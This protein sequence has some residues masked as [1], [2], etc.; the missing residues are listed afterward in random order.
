MALQF[1]I[2]GAGS[3][4][5]CT[6]FRRIIE[7]S[8]RERRQRFL[9]LVPEQS[10]METQRQIVGLHDRGGI[11]NIEVLSMTRLA[12]RVFS[13]LGDRKEELLEEIGKTFL[14]KKIAMDEKKNLRFFGDLLLKPE[15]LAQ[16]KA[17]ISEFLLYGVTPEML[18]GIAGEG[19]E[20][21]GGSALALKLADLSLLY[22]EFRR[23]L[24]GSYMTA[25]EIPER[26]SRLVLRSAYLRDSVIALDG[27]TGFTPL[28]LVLIEKLMTVSR[29]F[30][31]TVTMDAEESPFRPFRTNELFCLSGEMVQSL[32]EIARRT[33]TPIAAPYRVQG[34]GRHAGAPGLMALERS[35][36]RR[37]PAGMDGG[38]VRERSGKQEIRLLYL[39]SPREEIRRT[40][41]EI[42][43]LVRKEGMRYRDFA[44]VTADLHTYGRYV[45]ELFPE[46]EI[47]FFIDE[48]RALKL[49]PFMEY[50]RAAL[51]AVTEQY[52]I[53]GMLRMLKSGMTDFRKEE[54]DCLENYV[55]ALGIK[56]KER[57]HKPFV[58]HYR[59]EDPGEVPLL[60]GL[61][62]RILALLDPFAEG[63]A[64]RAGTVREK[65]AAL[66]EFCLRSRAEERLRERGEMYREQGRPDLARE[67]AQI[68]PYIVSFLDKLV[69]VLGDEAI[70]MK[71]YRELVEAGFAEGRLAIIPPGNDQVLVGD[72]ERSRLSGVRV[73]FFVGVNEGLVPK[74][75]VSTSILTQADRDVL[76]ER[77]ISLKPSS[78]TQIYIDR[79]YLYLTLT[80]PSR[81]LV[82][83]CCA[84]TPSGE[85]ARPS[86]LIDTVRT[87]FP[88][89][90][91]EEET[92]SLAAAVERESTGISLL[93]RG[94]SRLNEE[95]PGSDFKELFSYYRHHP[96]YGKR[97]CLLLDAA[98]T[99]KDGDRI[100]RAAARALYGDVL[101]NSAS[102]LEL[103][104]S[105]RYAH[106]LAYGLKLRPRQ[107]CEFTGLDM[108]S[109]L[110]R[111]F[112]LFQKRLQE[113]NRS[114]SSF[115]EGGEELAER[116]RSCLGEAVE[117]YGSAVLS[118]SARDA[119]QVTRMLR[120]MDEAAWAQA[121]ILSAGDFEPYA[122][123]ESFRGAEL[124]RMELENGAVMQLTGRID[125]I[126]IYEADGRS[127]LEIVD[128]K[129]G[130]VSFDLTEVY[131][132]LQLQLVLYLNAAMETLRRQGREVLPAGIFYYRIQ[133]PVIPYEMGESE[134]ETKKRL[135]SQ[136]RASGAVLKDTGFVRHFD[137]D[138]V[139]GR[140]SDVLPLGLK[141]DG[142]FKAGSSVLTDEEFR[143]LCAYVM[144]TIRR[145]AFE[146]TEGSAEVNPYSYRQRTACDYCDYRGI[147]GFDR[148]IPGCRLRQLQ[149][150]DTDVLLCRM[151]EMPGERDEDCE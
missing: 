55:I 88:D 76:S 135:L 50:L 12:S 21:G 150:M 117:E 98:S 121:K 11:L 33:G 69:A 128:Y 13:E 36:F 148:R 129:T 40:G 46:A 37:K 123:E 97:I 96:Q 27:F 139:P 62:L 85:S 22:R 18:G 137:R 35:L 103:F 32:A 142:D 23:R 127:Y 51:E 124:F 140:S 91:A 109:I 130:S 146:I 132:G 149:K 147:C 14:L 52:S 9:I 59:G 48:K 107:V 111:A 4:K 94:L 134:E 80:K 116:T 70:S 25:E 54:I 29:D 57:W 81:G 38:A 110:H 79:F 73:L 102:R 122:A 34:P 15:F 145:A 101:Q 39:A 30:Y 86:S 118:D 133:D 87:L 10:T 143:T 99:R 114:W 104:M 60:D 72:M 131:Y 49:N 119:Y 24:E 105:C 106:F 58:R 78:R 92:D 65:T 136:M 84:Q 6:L 53:S 20:E 112:E 41:R 68:W 66:Y 74:S 95:A 108:G 71:D 126:D 47:P 42:C 16:M 2:G 93:I 100:S 89:L 82:L 77:K 120:L 19:E 67:Y 44:I 5:S 43:R 63:M 90:R 3:G 31:V 26:L 113:E 144:R 7:E 17:A 75:A 56:G 83:S 125:R 1:Y 64:L 115:A 151:S 8:I 45:R 141:Q 28:Q 138:L 61:R